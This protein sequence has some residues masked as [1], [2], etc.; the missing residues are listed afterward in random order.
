MYLRLLLVFFVLQIS[1]QE[2]NVRQLDLGQLIEDYLAK[3]N[4]RREEFLNKINTEILRYIYE[5][6]N[7]NKGKKRIEASADKNVLEKVLTEVPSIR[8][9]VTSKESNVNK[10]HNSLDS[11]SSIRSI[12]TGTLIFRGKKESN[13]NNENASEQGAPGSLLFRGKKEPNVKENSKNETEASHGERLQQ[14]ERNFL[15]KTKEYI[16]KLLNSGEE[17]V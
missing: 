13:S 8:E 14:T 2:S 9:S 15:V 17:I 7:E 1:L 12:P 6:E 10:M 4:V 5:L 11:K 16:E 3:E